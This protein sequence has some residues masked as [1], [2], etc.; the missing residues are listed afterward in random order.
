MLGRLWCATTI[1]KLYC[2]TYDPG[3]ETKWECDRA[4]FRYQWAAGHHG[5][6]CE[7]LE[8]GHWEM[9]DIDGNSL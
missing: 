1:N 9:F 6:A 5:E 7:E 4:L 3:F 2:L 8:N